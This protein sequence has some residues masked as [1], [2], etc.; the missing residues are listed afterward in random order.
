MVNDGSLSAQCGSYG[1]DGCPCVLS[2]LKECL[3]CSHLQGKEL[4][5]CQWN[6]YCVFI[7]YL[8]DHKD[9]QAPSGDFLVPVRVLSM[10]PAGKRVFLTAPRS[11]L[12]R[13]ASL[14][15]VL[16]KDRSGSGDEIPAVVLSTYPGHNLISLAVR[17]LVEFPE[18]GHTFDL[19][20]GLKPAVDGLEL[21]L[22]SCGR[23]VLVV[24][25]GYGQLLIDPLIKNY[26]YP[27]H[28]ATVVTSQSLPLITRNII[29]LNAHC[30]NVGAIN[31]TQLHQALEGKNYD[32]CFSLGS[33]DLA[34]Q[35]D[36]ALSA[37]GGRTRHFPAIF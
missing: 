23:N 4:C 27:G 26:L 12:D 28:R 15:Q 35:V 10:D 2:V 16:I 19:N 21:V 25:E 22:E 24:A 20:P 34:R 11:V 9:F 14:Q 8:H 13:T 32:I 17:Q 1:S 7:N 30:L 37:L 6:K 3:V 18:E 31:G 36:L 29:G 5:D 33:P